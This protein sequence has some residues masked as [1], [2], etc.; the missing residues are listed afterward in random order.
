M[1]VTKRSFADAE[2]RMAELRSHGHAVSARFD[3][4][5]ARVVIAL[6]NGVELA[7]PVGL[8]EGLAGAAPDDLA[9]IEVTPGGLGL[10]WPCLDADVHVPG[11][12]QGIFGS[13][14]WMA[15][16]L[17]ATGGRVSSPAKAEAAR[18]NGR[19]GGRPKKAA[20]G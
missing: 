16:Q 9:N 6:H 18:A 5:H 2:A 11:L 20:G 13:R 3:R 17:G 19:R 1:A 4:K 10:H 12:M 14:R 15:A 7:V 8:V